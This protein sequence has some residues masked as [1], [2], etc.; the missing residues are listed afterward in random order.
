MTINTCPL[1]AGSLFASARRLPCSQQP[2]LL[3]LEFWEEDRSRLRN[4][5][6]I[7]WA[8]SQLRIL[9]CS[10]VLC[11][12]TM[13]HTVSDSSSY[14]SCRNSC[15]SQTLLVGGPITGRVNTVLYDITGEM[16]VIVKGK[17]LYECKDE[18]F[19]S[20]RNSWAEEHEIKM[21]SFWFH[22]IIKL[23]DYC[24]QSN[25]DMHPHPSNEKHSNEHQDSLYGCQD[26]GRE[27]KR[28]CFSKS[29]L[30]DVQTAILNFVLAGLMN[31]TVSWM[32][33]SPSVA[34]YITRGRSLPGPFAPN[35][36]AQQGYQIPQPHQATQ[37][38]HP[39]ICLYSADRLSWTKGSLIVFYFI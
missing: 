9:G 16:L 32:R 24:I 4:M 15:G 1:Q 35:C 5:L 39:G 26:S 36:H 31:G 30:K 34:D 22:F 21:T 2:S 11:N 23:R 38:K 14:R 7:Y 29:R 8:T 3:F 18:I 17:R 19:G 13:S 6:W 37:A 27:K 25:N 28:W 12:I 10:G 20:L 33:K